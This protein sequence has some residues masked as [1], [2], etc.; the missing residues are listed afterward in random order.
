MD[1]HPE[2]T[3]PSNFHH[4]RDTT[5]FVDSR[6]D[7]VPTLTARAVHAVNGGKPW[8]ELKAEQQRKK[9]SS[10]KRQINNAAVSRMTVARLAETDPDDE[11]R[12]WLTAISN[13]MAAVDR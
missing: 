7:D 6:P 3:P 13:M 5:G 9:E 10:A 4:F 8:A 11:I 12:S 2:I 1:V